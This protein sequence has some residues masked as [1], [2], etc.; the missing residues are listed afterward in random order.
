MSGCFPHII[1]YPK[2]P[3][4]GTAVTGTLN[5]NATG[6]DHF[7]VHVPRSLVGF[8]PTGSVTMQS[9]SAYTF[10]RNASASVE[11]T[12]AEAQ[13]DISPIMVDG[14]CCRDVTI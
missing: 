5:L 4:G 1:D 14:V 9:F 10:V 13:A 3:R 11:F 7:V 6:H 8:P 2:P 12:N